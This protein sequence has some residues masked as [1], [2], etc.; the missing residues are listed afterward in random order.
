MNPVR[1]G[2]SR[3]DISNGGEFINM[4]IYYLKM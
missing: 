3:R 4:Q 1:N 2:A